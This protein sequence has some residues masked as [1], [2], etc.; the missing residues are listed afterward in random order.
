MKTLFFD[1]VSQHIEDC[2]VLGLATSE[3]ALSIVLSSAKYMDEEIKEV[4]SSL[5]VEI[6][7]EIRKIIFDYENTREYH[8]I[9]STGVTRDLSEIINR[10]K[11]L[12]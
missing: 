6:I 8:V 2:K 3:L 12:A 10:I 1:E 9:S 5:P 4:F 11:K 7:E